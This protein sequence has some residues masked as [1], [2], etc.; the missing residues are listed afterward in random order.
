MPELVCSVDPH[1]AH[2][3]LMRLSHGLE[4][5]TGWGVTEESLGQCLPAGSSSGEGQHQGRYKICAENPFSHQS[6]GLLENDVFG[7]ALGVKSKNRD[8]RT[9]HITNGS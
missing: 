9:G 3:R 7:Q 6:A 1:N 4:R 2:P 8:S 5:S